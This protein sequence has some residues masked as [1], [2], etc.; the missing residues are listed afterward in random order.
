MSRSL[1]N[2]ITDDFFDDISFYFWD[3]TVTRTARRTIL[4][5]TF[6]FFEMF[7]FFIADFL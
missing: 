7:L 6:I 1:F 4:I 2:T 3:I 5:Y